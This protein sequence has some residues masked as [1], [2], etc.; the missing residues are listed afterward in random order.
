MRR[1]GTV[2]MKGPGGETLRFSVPACPECPR[3]TVITF[4]LWADGKIDV[5]CQGCDVTRTYD[6][7]TLSIPDDGARPDLHVHAHPRPD[8]GG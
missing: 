6:L 8:R 1:L 7:A 2:T 3:P 4:Q 5:L